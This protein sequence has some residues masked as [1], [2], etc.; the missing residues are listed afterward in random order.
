MIRLS[1]VWA[2]LV[3]A[4][5]LFVIANAPA[6]MLKPYL[7]NAL[8]LPLNLNGTIW[9]GSATSQHFQKVSWQVEPLYL[10]TGQLSAKIIIIIDDANQINTNANI[11][12]AKTLDFS[13]VNGKLTTKYLQQFS[14]ETPFMFS[15][16]I[17][18]NQAEAKWSGDLPPNLPI[19][20][21]GNILG[22]RVNLLGEKLGSY[23]LDYTYINKTLEGDITSTDDSSV[24]TKLK[25]NISP[26]NVLTLQGE[27]LPKSTGLKTIFEELNIAFNPNIKIQLPTF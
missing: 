5:V 26:Q 21:K 1:K 24:D 25:L 7:E 14:P 10:L 9:Q 12:L 20:S 11:N 13:H 3:I 4:T 19:T 2:T 8:N 6:Q 15:A 23:Q 27:V 22:E 16:N 18:I 17:N